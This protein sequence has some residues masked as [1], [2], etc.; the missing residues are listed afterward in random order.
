MKE[1]SELFMMITEAPTLNQGSCTLESHGKKYLFQLASGKSWKN[2]FES[3]KVMEFF[4][5]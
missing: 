2:Y 4:F 5:A 3:L 1:L